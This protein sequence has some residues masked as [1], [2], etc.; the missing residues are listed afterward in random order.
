MPRITSQLSIS[1]DGFVAGP[2]QSLEH[3]L[4]VG[5]ERLHQWAFGSEVHATD[6]EVAA[7]LLDGNGAYVMGRNMFAGPGAWDESWRGWWGEDPPYHVP[8]FVVTHHERK[9]LPMRGGTTFFFVTGGVEDALARAREAAG[10]RDV[11]I[12]GG[13][14]IVRQVLAAGALDELYLHIVPV[15]LGAGERLFEG[16]RDVAL[17]PVKV[18]GSPAV[19]HVRYRVRR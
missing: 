15:L 9:P 12:A 7:S 13:A 4:G 14:G 6:A 1:L 5:G 10:D 18:I 19:T 8:V 2:G 16:V 17:E 11:C 3:P